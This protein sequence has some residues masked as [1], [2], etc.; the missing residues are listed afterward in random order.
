MDVS[1]ASRFGLRPAPS[2]PEILVGPISGTLN[3]SNGQFR[4]STDYEGTSNI[5]QKLWG[6]MTGKHC[7]NFTLFYEKLLVEG[8]ARQL[9]LDGFKN[10]EIQGRKI[11][12]GGADGRVSGFIQLGLFSL[13]WCWFVNNVSGTQS[14]HIHHDSHVIR[15]RILY[16]C[17]KTLP[18]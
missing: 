3:I 1:A 15:R 13:A 5:E 9:K 7:W 6:S 14:T 2:N 11:L 18:P 8:L 16:S 10:L 17:R 4:F 12:I